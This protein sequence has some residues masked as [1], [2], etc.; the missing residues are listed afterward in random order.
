VIIQ[1]RLESGPDTLQQHKPVVASCLAIAALSVWLRSAV[2]VF[3]IGTAAHDDLLFVRLAY[4]LGG[5]LWLGPFDQLTLAKGMAYPA[6]VVLA[7]AVGIPLKV[8]EQA[9]YLA[10]AGLAAWLVN[11]LTRSGW[12]AVLLFACL[13][14]N[15][16]LWTT[17]LARVI[18]EGTY[19]SLSLAVVMLTVI[20]LVRRDKLSA[21]VRGAALTMLG[22]TAGLYWLTREEGVWLAPAVAFLLVAAAGIEIWQ[23][24]RSANWRAAVRKVAV[25]LGLAVI[26]V[27]IFAAILGAVAGMNYRQYGAFTANELQSAPFR[28]AYGAIS[29]IGHDEWHRYIVFPK[30]A[31]ERAYSVSAAARELRPTLDGEVGENWRLMGCTQMRIEVCRGIPAGWFVWGFRDAVAAAGHYTSAGSALT[32]YER[33]AAEI[34]GACDDGRIACLAPRATMTPPFHWEFVGDTLATIPALAKMLIYPG[35]VGALP[36]DGPQFAIDLFADLVGPVAAAPLSYRVLLMTVTAPV[37]FPDFVIRD[38]GGAPYRSELRKALPTKPASGP[39][40]ETIA[41]ELAT[42][43]IRPSCEL[44]VRSGSN[45]QS[46]PIEELAA[47]PLLASQDTHVLLRHIFKRGRST[48]IPVASEIRRDLQLR[49]MRVIATIYAAVLPVLVGLGALGV[50][51]AIVLRRFAPPTEG[52]LALVIAC[53][54]AVVTR[55]VLLAYIDVSAFSAANSLY[56]SSASP[57]LLIFSILGV[58]L[59]VRAG[60]AACSAKLRRQ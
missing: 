18:R 53:A 9:L 44:V 32:F 43:C 19:V 4:Y 3:A 49:V 2:P 12:L 35:D 51:L 30:D 15:P 42:D 56:L 22:V 48:A 55:M 59:G 21:K 25:I 50:G 8:A 7:F 31:R 54:I 45:E 16:A 24:W 36:S 27:A 26:P 57:F 1:D 58:Y 6:F 41:V 38:R 34:N 29:R 5:G 40:A 14:L 23:Y 20:V 37:E 46:F 17:Q 10:A 11:R 39:G 28:A 60:A 33:L 47:G 52:M 13:A